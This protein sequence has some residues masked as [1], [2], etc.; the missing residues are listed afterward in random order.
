MVS[1]LE[2]E[3][4]DGAS[5]LEIGGGV[6]ELQVELLHR[7]AAT[8]TNLEIATTYEDEARRL[9]DAH[10]LSDRAERRLVDIAEAPDAVEPADVVV[11]HRV[12]CCYDDYERLLAAAGSHA[13]RALVFS[14]PPR[15][16]GFRAFM[17]A[18][19]LVMRLSGHEYRAFAHPPREMLRVLREQGLRPT[20]RHRGLLWHV[21][22]LTR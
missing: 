5:V 15:N 1:F 8:T 11:L 16:P 13:R 3:G 21:A 18:N 19:N 17:A 14:H 6:G 12:V 22:G 9:L 10:G 20:Y 2:R 7:G 4:V